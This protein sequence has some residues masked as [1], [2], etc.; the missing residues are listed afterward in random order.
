MENFTAFLLSTD[1]KTPI[2]FK[3]ISSMRAVIW[4]ILKSL[5]KQDL[6]INKQKKTKCQGPRFFLY[7][8][9]NLEF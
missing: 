7:L 2:I 6:I 8:S 9:L 4:K 3:D 5:N 1:K